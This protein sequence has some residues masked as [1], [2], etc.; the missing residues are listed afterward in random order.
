MASADDN[1]S[2]EGLSWKTEAYLGKAGMKV[3][4]TER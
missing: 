4:A 1:A 3:L 2:T